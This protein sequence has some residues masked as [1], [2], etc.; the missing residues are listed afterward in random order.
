MSS[1][2]ERT[3]DRTAARFAAAVEKR[4]TYHYVVGKLRGDPAT[5]AVAALAPLGEVL[6]LGC[7]RGHLAVYLLECGAAKSIRGF[8]W[9]EQKIA[10]A[11]RACHGLDASFTAADVRS[12]DA[13]PADTV[14][15]VD[16]LHYLD[17][18]A[19]DAL[20]ARA[21]E[22]VRPGGRLVVRDATAGGGWRSLFTLFVEWI[23][24]LV[25]FNLGER[26]ALR[27]VARDLVPQ[28]ERRGF[29]CTVEPCWRG[30]PFANVLMVAERPRALAASAASSRS[31]SGAV[32]ASAPSP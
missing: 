11:Q 7:G 23:S 22:L 16:V 4:A 29:A 24:M 3:I 25:R 5:R 19:Q 6:D 18:A 26:I 20:L 21:A 30:T 13:A 8:D 1:D 27:D 12:A 14:L 10:L 31:A 2:P 17:A 32:E 15:L 9:D 28:L